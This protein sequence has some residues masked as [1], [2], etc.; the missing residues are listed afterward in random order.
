MD[1]RLWPV[2]HQSN[3][4]LAKQNSIIITG[5]RPIP[6][7]E[8]CISIAAVAESPKLDLA[9]L[10]HRR[11]SEATF[12]RRCSSSAAAHCPFR[13]WIDSLVTDSPNN[14]RIICLSKGTQRTKP[15]LRAKLWA[16][17]NSNPGVVQP[18]RPSVIQTEMEAMEQAVHF[19]QQ[20]R[21]C[22]FQ[23]K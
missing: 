9:F 6:L 7:F 1:E 12:N 10:N 8:K 4:P 20:K 21:I 22:N 23:S 5:F 16:S 13:P 18:V 2:I 19:G 17:M 14:K 3:G 15:G 11:S